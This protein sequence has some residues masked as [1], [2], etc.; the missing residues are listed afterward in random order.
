M[1]VSQGPLKNTSAMV[2]TSLGSM[3]MSKACGIA[4]SPS[5][6]FMTDWWRASLVR[7]EAPSVRMAELFKLA[8]EPRNAETPTYSILRPVAIMVETLVS[9][10]EKSKLQVIGSRENAVRSSCNARDQSQRERECESG[11]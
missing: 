5:S 4:V 7:M 9:T 10:L 2:T 8:R 1:P 11:S 3:A 6:T